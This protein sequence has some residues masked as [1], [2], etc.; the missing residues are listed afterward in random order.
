MGLRS[1]F[2][3]LPAILCGLSAWPSNAQQAQFDGPAELPRV[4]VRSAMADTPAP[5]NT[6]AVRAGDNLQQA[7]NKA[8]CGDTI[9]LQA[10]EVFTGAFHF[11]QKACDDAH[12]VV[13]RTSAPNSA[14]PPEGTRLKP[15][16]GGVSS[17]PGRPDFH[18]TATENVVA[19]LELRPREPI[20]PILFDPGA[21]HY[22]FTGL[23]V[24]RAR[25]DQP[26]SALAII[27][28]NGPQANGQID[29]IIF[30]RV[31][32]HGTAQDETTRG[33]YLVGMS[34]VAVVDS[35]FND[36]VCVSAT[37]SCT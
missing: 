37:G 5:G 13:V 9:Q 1:R 25:G 14:L 15:C 2:A 4:Y 29:H 21:N 19:K 20:G 31:W 34:Y 36:F 12:W 8:E 7:I 22:R 10:G 16:Y 26:V 24:T 17:L 11:P 30:D 32:M 23:E 18:C 3:I 27:K 33:I 6:I 35:F 28:G